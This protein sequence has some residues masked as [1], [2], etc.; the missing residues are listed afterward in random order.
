[1]EDREFACRPRPLTFLPLSS[2]AL[3]DSH[4]MIFEP[5]TNRPLVFKSKVL[6]FGARASVFGF[7]RTAVGLWAVGVKLLFLHW[8][9][10][11]DDFFLVCGPDEEKHLDLAQRLLFQ[12]LGWETSIEEEGEFSEL[13]RVLGVEIELAS[14]RVGVIMARNA[15][16]RIKEISEQIDSILEHGRYSR[17]ELKVLRGRLQFPEQQF[18]GRASAWMVKILNSSAEASPAG[19]VSCD[20]DRALR[21]LTH[22]I[23]RSGPRELN[24]T[25]GKTWYLF[26]DAFFEGRGGL[27]GI[28]FDPAGHTHSWFSTSVSPEQCRVLNPELKQTIISELEALAVLAGA[29]SL[30]G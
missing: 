23:N 18:F 21:F 6:V 17:G 27:S 30:C 8:T 2:S 12:L 26:T 20:L 11:F 4:L 29:R 7:C 1:M 3:S 15:S 28:L 5:A 9:Q 14:A 10:Y 25:M 16:S 19:R 22:R 24:A 13:A